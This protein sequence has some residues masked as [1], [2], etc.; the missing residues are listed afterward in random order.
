MHRTREIHVSR[1]IGY[2]YINLK[3]RNVHVMS[4]GTDSNG[5]INEQAMTNARNDEV[6]VGTA[7]LIPDQK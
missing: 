1:I 3:D 6:S 2:L 5:N 7:L 4:H